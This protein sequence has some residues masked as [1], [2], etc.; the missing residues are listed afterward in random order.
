MELADL[1]H[2]EETAANCHSLLLLL[3]RVCLLHCT[4][5]PSPSMWRSCRGACRQRTRMPASEPWR[6]TAQPTSWRKHKHIEDI[7]ALA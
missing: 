5:R 6:Q 1:T 3:L 4:C 2:G 7:D